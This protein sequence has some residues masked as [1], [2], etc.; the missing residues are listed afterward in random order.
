MTDKNFE[1]MTDIYQQESLKVIQQSIETRFGMPTNPVTRFAQDCIDRYIS[2]TKDFRSV[3]TLSPLEEWLIIQLYEEKTLPK[4]SGVVN[5]IS[6][7]LFA[8]ALKEAKERREIEM[9][10]TK[11]LPA[12]NFIGQVGRNLVSQIDK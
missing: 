8:S 1:I 2:A 7:N 9:S 6:S 11:P 5:G 12:C 10:Q 4:L 3:D